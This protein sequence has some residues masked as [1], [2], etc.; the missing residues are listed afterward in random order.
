MSNLLLFVDPL[1]LPAPNPSLSRPGSALP[2]SSVRWTGA[3]PSQV[4]PGALYLGLGACHSSEGPE[5][6]LYPVMLLR[7]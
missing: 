3:A 1:S 6:I 2:P 4:E 7:I 5:L